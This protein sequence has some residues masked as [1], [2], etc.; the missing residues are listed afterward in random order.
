[1][2]SWNASTN[3]DNNQGNMESWNA[4]TNVG[5]NQ[6]ALA[7]GNALSKTNDKDR[8]GERCKQ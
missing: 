6:T 1:M 2:D 3:V 7:S 5:N 4:N 8:P